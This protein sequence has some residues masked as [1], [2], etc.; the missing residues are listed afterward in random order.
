MRNGGLSVVAVHDRTLFWRSPVTVKRLRFDGTVLAE[1]THWRLCADRLSAAELPI[2]ANVATPGDPRS[3]LLIATMHDS[4]AIHYF[5]ED[6]DLDLLQPQADYTLERN[7]A[8]EWTLTVTARSLLKDVCIFVDHLHP[9]ATISDMLVT[10]LPGQSHAFSIACA[11]DLD[12]HQL[13]QPPVLRCANQL[14]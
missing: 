6:I 13:A 8:A 10:L 11:V 3:E 12:L 1:W 7:G 4:T 5:A 2:P 14:V 9:D